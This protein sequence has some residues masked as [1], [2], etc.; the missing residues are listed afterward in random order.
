VPD[1]TTVLEPGDE[2]VALTAVGSVEQVRALLAE[3]AGPDA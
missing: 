2:V 3:P 1:G